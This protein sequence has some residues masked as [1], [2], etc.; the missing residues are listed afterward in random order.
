MLLTLTLLKEHSKLKVHVLQNGKVFSIKVETQP[1]LSFQ[2]CVVPLNL[3]LI[4]TQVQ[5]VCV[6]SLLEHTQTTKT[7]NMYKQR[8]CTVKKLNMLLMYNNPKH[9]KYLFSLEAAVYE[10]VLGS[11]SSPL[12]VTYF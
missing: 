6:C 8:R 10:I 1:A 11:A 5:K 9:T 7:C 12:L 4:L 2:N 3:I